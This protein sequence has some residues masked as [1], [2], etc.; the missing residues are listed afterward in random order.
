MRRGK[1]TGKIGKFPHNSLS[2]AFVE[3]FSGQLTILHQRRLNTFLILLNVV[4]LL[5]QLLQWKSGIFLNLL[6]FYLFLCFP[7]KIEY[8][9]STA[10]SCSVTLVD[11]FDLPKTPPIFHRRLVY[12]VSDLIKTRLTYEEKKE[13]T[14]YWMPRMISI[15]WRLDCL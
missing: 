3:T 9:T 5:L 6:C 4:S 11:F 12:L 7:S 8:L 1:T 10:T 14:L 15:N 2:L 13:K